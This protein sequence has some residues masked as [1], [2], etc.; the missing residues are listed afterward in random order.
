[1]PSTSP[2]LGLPYPLASDEP[3]APGAIFALTDRLDKLSTLWTTYTPGGNWTGGSG[4]SSTFRYRLEN[5]EMRIRGRA[6]MGASPAI[7]T[8]FS[9]T[10]PAGFVYAPWGV[11]G[12][13]G[14]ATLAHP[15]TG[16]FNAKV[17][18]FNAAN[19]SVLDT[20]TPDSLRISAIGTNGLAIDVN[21]PFTWVSGDY[22]EVDA[23]VPIIP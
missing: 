12:T 1:M 3:D 7:P 14:S 20:T 8:Y 17:T 6:R 21:T 5:G 22:F 18:T 4:S 16:I 10:L 11:Y 23:T 19:S 9:L 2:N 15:A 13:N